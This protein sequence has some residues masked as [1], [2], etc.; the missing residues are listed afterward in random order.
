MPILQA[1]CEGRVGAPTE[2]RLV[3]C[4]ALEMDAQMVRGYIRN[5]PHLY[6]GLVA[7]KPAMK[8]FQ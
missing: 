6:E 8:G 4:V 5:P 2:Q 3:L 7:C 1:A